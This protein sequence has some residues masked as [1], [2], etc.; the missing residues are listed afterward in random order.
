[1]KEKKDYQI[2]LLNHL[3]EDFFVLLIKLEL[4]I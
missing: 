3:T 4:Y 2:K 1:M